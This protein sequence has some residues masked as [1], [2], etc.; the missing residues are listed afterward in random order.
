MYLIVHITKLQLQTTF[1]KPLYIPHSACIH[2]DPGRWKSLMFALLVTCE[3]ATYSSNATRTGNWQRYWYQNL[4]GAPPG[5][6]HAFPRQRH[7][8]RG[9]GY[10]FMSGF[11]S[12]YDAI[13]R[14]MMRQMDGWKKLHEKWPQHPLLYVLIW[15]TADYW[16]LLYY[17]FSFLAFHM[18][19]KTLLLYYLGSF[20]I[21]F[22]IL[23]L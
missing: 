16:L 10:I 6:G 18:F 20:D 14:W 3:I 8:R 23:F 2:R 21:I 22:C 13:H 9:E 4:G 7:M 15:C 5:V 17:I 12:L 11:S 1:P 19:L